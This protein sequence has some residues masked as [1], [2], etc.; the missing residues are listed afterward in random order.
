MPTLGLRLLGPDCKDLAYRLGHCPSIL[1][2][3]F[4]PSPAAPI[5]STPA[6]PATAPLWGDG[7]P[8]ASEHLGPIP[9]G[10]LVVRRRGTLTRKLAAHRAEQVTPSPAALLRAE[11]FP[12]NTAWEWRAEPPQTRI[13]T[14]GGAR[15][16]PV[17]RLL[18]VAGVSGVRLGMC[19][20]LAVA[21]GQERKCPCVSCLLSCERLEHGHSQSHPWRPP[22]WAR[23]A[24]G[25]RLHSAAPRPSPRPAGPG[26]QSGP[27]LRAAA[28]GTRRQPPGSARSTPHL[29]AVDLQV[30]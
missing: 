15:R 24:P 1:S 19:G 20:S 9:P 18:P 12:G 17:A 10:A 25:A 21:G 3:F 27:R 4:S 2:V 8:E 11:V 7:A 30:A 23:E 5:R 29:A 22:A 13:G 26:L 6:L 28:S 14:L 16:A